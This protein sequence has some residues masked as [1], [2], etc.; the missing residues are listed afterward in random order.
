MDVP[1]RRRGRALA[2][3]TLLAVPLL[4]VSTPATAAPGDPLAPRVVFAEDFENGQGSGVI[5]VDDYTG[6]APLA[7]TYRVDPVWL[8]SCNGIIAS[9]LNQATDPPG[10]GC[11]GWWPRV[12]D[13]ARVLGDHADGTGATNHAVTAYTHTNP[14]AGRTQL[15]TVTPIPLTATNR[16]VAFSVDVAEQNCYAD[17]AR[18]A[19]YLLD[20]TTAVPAFQRPI[21]PCEDATTVVDATSVGTFHSD[22][23]VLFSGTSVGLRLVNQQPSGNGNDSAFDNIRVLDVTP[24]L[25]VAYDPGAIQV[26]GTSAL[27]LTVTNTSELSKKAGWSFTLDLPPGVAPAGPATT[28]CADTALDPATGDFRLRATGTIP[29]GAASCAV[30]VP[31]RPETVG[32]Y[33]TCAAD[34]G[35]LIGLDPPGC[36][37]L[38][39]T[40]PPYTYD[41][42]AYGARVS[43]LLAALPPVSPA[44]LTCATDPA[45]RTSHLVGAPL[46][47]GSVST[48]DNEAVGTT[49]A[50]GLR[51]ARAT[52]RTASL[53]LVGGLITADELR[54]E[55]V[56]T[57]TPTGAVT[58]SGTSTLSNLRVAGVPI[59]PLKNLNITIPL[60]G[61][62]TT[63]EQLPTANGISVN[64]LHIRL[65]AGTDITIGHARAAL[66]T[67]GAP[68]NL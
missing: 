19:F 15:E 43:T 3:V 8:T 33:T 57:T 66:Y 68:C 29:A 56:A 31:V 58:T 16:F 4:V 60:V 46:P 67:P 13:L 37:T 12:R 28:T 51:T 10:A 61:T 5:W 18:Y 49:G 11:G 7:Q 9:A 55:A 34:V 62:V 14:G 42:H 6:P 2:A 25:D 26:G 64:A 63:N 20:G 23:P 27:T 32:T 44:D 35:P 38:T 50:D 48:M 39:V 36:S 54:A 21:T 53:S 40:A 30:T 59:V 47:V 41:A 45:T 52:A 1:S 17:H 65:I 24:R 22:A